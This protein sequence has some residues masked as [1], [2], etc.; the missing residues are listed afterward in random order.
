[1]KINKFFLGLAAIVMAGFT[2]S[3]D[4]DV[5]GPT[6]TPLASNVTFE[7]ETQELTTAEENITVPVRIVRATTKG[8][9][10]VNYTTETQDAVFTDENNG[11]VTFADGQGLAV[12]NIKASNMAKGV[13]YTLKLNLDE[14]TYKAL[15]DTIVDNQLLTSTIIVHSDY[16]WVALG[17][18]FYSSP[19]WW[20][21]EFYVDVMQAEGTNIYRLKSLFAS[22]Y[23]IDFTI[24]SDNKVFVDQQA[25]WKHSSYGTVYLWGYANEDSSGYA[26]P[27]DPTTK[28]ATLTLVHFVEAGS[29]GSYTDVLTMP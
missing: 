6:Y 11:Q 23:D 21:E 25:S 2:T 3:C 27:Y 16:N 4:T 24:T 8:N 15:A 29:F 26:G 28:K 18:G 13:D 9:L 20:E 1:M 19:E 5:E 10:T 12:I 7:S 17:K 14:A 22:G